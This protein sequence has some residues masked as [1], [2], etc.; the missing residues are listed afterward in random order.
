MSKKL[1]S[2]WVIASMVLALVASALVGAPA[3]VPRKTVGEIGIF[4]AAKFDAHYRAPRDAEVER[5]LVEEGVLLQGAG[6]ARSQAAVQEFKKE[7][8][9]RNPDTPNPGKLRKLLKTEQMK[10]KM[11]AESPIQSLVVPVEFPN[12]STFEWCGETVTM[13][14]PL[15]NEIAPPGPRDNNTIW[16]E[17]ATPELYKELYFAYGPMPA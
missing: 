6:L 2:T 9:K 15:H 11:L 10:G 1:L 16:Y 4:Q 7:W 13:A 17:D 5:I 3:N 14:G 12:E 8:H